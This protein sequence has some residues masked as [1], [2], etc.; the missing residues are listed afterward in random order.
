MAKTNIDERVSSSSAS[1]VAERLK[2]KVLEAIPLRALDVE[3]VSPDQLH[4]NPY[5]PNRE[6]D[7]EFALLRQSI[8]VDGFTLPV[9]ANKDYTI[10]DGEH[11]W[12]AA[13]AEG[14]KL[15]PVVRID[16]DDIKM[17]MST[18][19]HNKARGTHD[20]DLE[21]MVIA[22]LEKLMGV[23]FIKS[24]LMI[25]QS[26]LD[27]ILNFTNAPEMMAAEDWSSSWSPV[28]AEG[29]YQLDEKGKPVA[30][31]Q[32]D[33]RQTVDSAFVARSNSTQANDLAYRKIAQKDVEASKETLY[34]V[35]VVMSPKQFEEVRAVL[36]DISI[37]GSTP[38]ERFFHLCE[39]WE[40]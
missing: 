3:M 13:K 38:A 33:V 35:S 24:Q 39:S 22:D 10:I 31:P 12:Q 5:N 37:P 20:A 23:E 25:D 18:I 11:R 8:K 2:G 15:I 19:R 40:G 6:S 9:L 7:K 29:N 28:K 4:P 1:K 21:A 30:N 17:R 16:L 27:E 26:A 14:L 34:T 32:F 36:D